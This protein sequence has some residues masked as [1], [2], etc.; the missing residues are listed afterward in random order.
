MEPINLTDIV[1]MVGLFVTNITAIIIAWN[2]TQIKIKEIE[3]KLIHL[4][5]NLDSHIKWGEG[6]QMK[7]M[8][9]FVEI[10]KEIKTNQKEINNKLDSII[11]KFDDFRVYCVEKF[12]E[13]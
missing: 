6:E 7:N 8:E 9:K 3:V 1:V 12:L 10:D 4:S 5:K 2:R 11:E 13:K